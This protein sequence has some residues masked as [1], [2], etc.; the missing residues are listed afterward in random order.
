MKLCFAAVT[1]CML[2]FPCAARGEDATLGR[3]IDQFSLVDTHGKTHTQAEFADRKAIVLV[4][5]ATECPLA[6]AYAPRVAELATEVA[7]RGVTV[8][9]IAPGAPETPTRLSR[10]A[11]NYKLT[12]PLFKDHGSTLAD[13]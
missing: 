9:G 8:M 12:F 13:K 7:P 2:G 6:R 3:K 4:T 1:L 11:E 10:F 5:L